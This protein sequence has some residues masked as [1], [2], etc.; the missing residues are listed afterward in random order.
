MGKE[1]RGTVSDPHKPKCVQWASDEPI[2]FWSFSVL[3]GKISSL[4][5]SDEFDPKSNKKEEIKTD[6]NKIFYV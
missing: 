4:T 6:C 1:A 3:K 5:Q 2:Y